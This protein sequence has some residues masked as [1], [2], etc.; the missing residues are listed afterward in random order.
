MIIYSTLPMEIIFQNEDAAAYD[1]ME[2]QMNG[3]TMLVQPCGNNEARIVRLISPNPYDY[4][5][6]A[7]TPGRRIHFRPETVQ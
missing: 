7:Y 5:N 1:N 4:M 3:M 6:P 2:I